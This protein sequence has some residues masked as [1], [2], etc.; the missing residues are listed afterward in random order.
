MN[1]LGQQFKV[2]R[3]DRKALARA[4]AELME[5]HA[6]ASKFSE[7]IATFRER[8]GPLPPAFPHV[9]YLMMERLLGSS[10]DTKKR[11]DE[12]VTLVASVEPILGFRLRSSDSYPKIVSKLRMLALQDSQTS[13]AFQDLEPL[14]DRKTRET[15]K[16]LILEVAMKH[17]YVTWFRVRRMLNKPRE[18]PPEMESLL[19]KI[20]EMSK[21]NPSSL[22]PNDISKLLAQL[23]NPASKE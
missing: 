14:V 12:A 8:L 2:R 11:Y 19:Q 21:Q 20:S 17:G 7:V 23:E 9:F 16:E 6:Q 10:E 22:V 3:E 15:L 4:L 1:E 13:L 18:I 5:A